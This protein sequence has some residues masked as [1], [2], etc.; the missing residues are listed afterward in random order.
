VAGTKGQLLPVP[1]S[2]DAEQALI[3]GLMLDRSAWIDVDGLLKPADFYLPQHQVIFEAIEGLAR[4]DQT[5]D[6]VTVMESMTRAG[7]LTEA[8][9]LTYLGQLQRDTPGASNALQYARIVKDRAV[10]RE[11]IQLG[12]RM[13]A[14][15]SLGFEREELDAL[16]AEILNVTTER[17]TADPV[18]LFRGITAY[19]DEIDARAQRGD[20]LIGPSTGFEDLD[21]ITLGFEPGTLWYIGARPS[22]GKTSLA[23]KIAER[24]A[25][26]RKEPVA[27][28]SAEMPASQIYDRLLANTMPS[29]LTDIRSGQLSDPQWTS[30]TRAV[31]A[32][33]DKPFYIDDTPNISIGEFRAKARRLHQK[34]KLK[35]IVVDYLQLMAAPGN[36][37]NAIITNI[38]KGLKATAKELGCTVFA[39]A[40]L[41]REVEK[42]DSKRPFLSDLRGSGSV[43]QDGDVIGFLWADDINRPYRNLN[44][45]KH[46]NG[47]LG[48]IQLSWSPQ[49]VCFDDVDHQQQIEWGKQEQAERDSRKPKRRA[50]NPLDGADKRA[51][52]D[53]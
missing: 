30:L 25:L 26:Q 12:R 17:T 27:F 51:G 37:E 34:Y 35:L 3:G 6:I 50:R 31:K 5:A 20:R 42:R 4:A 47:A 2:E 22:M 9:G 21:K 46:R 44:L 41:N 28:F 11:M 40:Q 43:E 38:S 18:Q 7:T 45:A 19:I 24:M 48:D 10:R 14:M 36:D 53:D 1:H 15:A 13:A 39:L 8:G 16:Q 23:I 32:T 33:H 49:T 52:T 29:P